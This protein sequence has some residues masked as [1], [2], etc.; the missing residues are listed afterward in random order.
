[1]LVLHLG[2]S[3]LQQN[4][5]ACSVKL[6]QLR[7][8]PSHTIINT[9]Q[10]QRQ[11]YEKARQRFCYSSRCSNVCRV[12]KG[13]EAGEQGRRVLLLVRSKGCDERRVWQQSCSLRPLDG[14]PH[15]R[16]MPV[17]R[18]PHK[19]LFW[20]HD[21]EAQIDM[22]FMSQLYLLDGYK[23]IWI[24]ALVTPHLISCFCFP[25]ETVARRMGRVVQR[26]WYWWVL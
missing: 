1:M 20:L 15:S 4:S 18:H 13:G 9:Q 8:S 3:S 14:R 2:C 12:C 6:V 16:K 21:L 24:H 19:L 11:R 23:N 25:A 5:A 26:V 17:K 7:E 22:K 10:A